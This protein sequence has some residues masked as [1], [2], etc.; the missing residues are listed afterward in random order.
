[1]S[2]T[3]IPH[4]KV[5]LPPPPPVRSVTPTLD[6]SGH[7]E[8]AEVVYADGS[9]WTINFPPYP[10]ISP[11]SFTQSG[12]PPFTVD[13][14][15]DADSF[16]LTGTFQDDQVVVRVQ[17]T[18]EPRWDVTVNG[19]GSTVS[20]FP[21]LISTVYTPFSKKFTWGLIGDTSLLRTVCAQARA[22]TMPA[23]VATTGA[24]N[25]YLTAAV[26]MNLIP[27]GLQVGIENLWG[28]A[29]MAVA[30]MT[31]EPISYPL[32]TATDFFFGTAPGPY[33]TLINTLTDLSTGE[34][35]SGRIV[36]VAFPVGGV[37]PPYKRDPP[38]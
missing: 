8:S 30:V 27:P 18:G 10:A 7:Y 5:N 28:L 26:A 35:G 14:A 21:E 22:L 37:R 1:V 31:T 23:T 13:F 9:V 11:I 36:P 29:N 3:P 4:P 20:N 38:D 24:G 25:S 15:I 33:E 16:T 12:K 17:A 34:P 2:Q 6:K 19:F 32:T